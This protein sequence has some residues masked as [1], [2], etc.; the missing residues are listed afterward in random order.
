MLYWLTMINLLHTAD[1]HL[2]K[3]IYE[4]SLIAD[5]KKIMHQLLEE[6]C[7]KEHSTK[8]FYSALIISGDIYD[9]SIP[10]PEAIELFDEFLTKLHQKHPS[11]HIFIIPGNHDSAQRL[12]YASRI[13]R[14]QHIHIHTSLSDIGSY[15]LLEKENEKLAVFQIPFLRPSFFDDTLKEG[16]QGMKSQ[17]EILK[18]V[19]KTIHKKCIELQTDNPIPCIASAHLFTLGAQPS[20]SE[21]TF[22][23][24]AELI[25]ASLFKQFTYTALGHIHKPQKAG[26]RVYYAGSPLAYSFSEVGIDKNFL[27]IAVDCTELS[28]QKDAPPLASIQVHS[29]PVIPLRKTNKIKASFIDLYS[30]NEFDTYKDDYL[31]ITLCDTSL[32][33]NPMQLLKTKFPHLLSINQS[34]ALKESSLSSGAISEER[35]TALSQGTSME[36]IFSVFVK[37]LYG[38]QESTQIIENLLP[39]FLELTKEARQGENNL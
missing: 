13:L 35:K 32:I 33:E 21:R 4:H 1:L 2:G 14:G 10:P 6:A 36:E 20:D 12:S 25:D 11:L 23:G 9:R 22:L 39:L 5:Q 3:I 7:K 24:T 28:L 26:E 8:F 34:L 15:V 27:H 31:E 37:D 17:S 30:G 38:E 19:M 18:S 16:S 29:I